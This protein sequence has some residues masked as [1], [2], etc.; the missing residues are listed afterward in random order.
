MMQYF[1]QFAARL[2]LRSAD[3]I[4]DAF[5]LY[6]AF[7]DDLVEKDGG[8]IGFTVE[9]DGDHAI[10]IRDSEAHGDPENAVQFALA[11]A[12]AFG[13][14]GRWGF[15]WSSTCSQPSSGGF[16]GGAFLVDLGTRK[17][18]S[19]IDCESWLSAGLSNVVPLPRRG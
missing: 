2:D 13:L 8:A 14:K 5:Q 7:R 3:Y 17:V 12:G 9:A 18:I 19:E 10:R 6:E 15:T 1:T 4:S 11:C 16:S